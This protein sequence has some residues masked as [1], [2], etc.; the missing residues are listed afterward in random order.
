MQHTG[1]RRP[2]AGPAVLVTATL[3]AALLTLYITLFRIL[4]GWGYDFASFRGASIVLA[5]G[6]IPY[7]PSVLFATER[8]ELSAGIAYNSYNNP[9]LFA[10]VLWPLTQVPFV[11]SYLIYTALVMAA[12]IAGMVLTLRVLDIDRTSRWLVL[13]ALISAPFFLTVWFGQQAA[14]LLCVLAASM[15][16]LRRNQPLACGM[17]MSLGLVKPHLMLPLFLCALLLCHAPTARLRYVAG[18]VSA[19]MVFVAVSLLTSG[20]APLGAWLGALLQ[21]SSHVEQVQSNLPSFGGTLLILLPSPINRVAAL[22]ITAAAVAVMLWL[23]LAWRTVAAWERLAIAGAV[24]LSTVPYM[25]T[26]DLLLALPA[27]FVL[28]R[29]RGLSLLTLIALWAY[30]VLPFAYPLPLPWRLL[31]LLPLPIM[32]AA[33]LTARP[34]AYDQLA[35]QRHAQAAA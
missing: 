18:F 8:Q 23:C 35:G 21:L 26:P 24:W 34:L 16:L 9:P 11:A 2:L 7:R 4:P 31:D 15:L 10:T 20:L 22:A 33:L 32:L 12:G 1:S 5:H 17:V 3:A 27:L 19:V 30:M 13:P 25:H 6:G 29:W 28:W 14:F